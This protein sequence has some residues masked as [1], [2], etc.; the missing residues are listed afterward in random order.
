LFNVSRSI[1][2]IIK[3]TTPILFN[4]SISS[5]KESLQVIDEGF[6]DATWFDRNARISREYSD[7]ISESINTL[8]KDLKEDVRRSLARNA[9]RDRQE[10]LE[11]LLN[12]TSNKF[13]NYYTKERANMIARTNT[14]A[15]DNNVKRDTWTKMGVTELEWVTEGDDRV[16]DSH[17]AMDGQLIPI[18]GTFTIEIYDSQG[19]PTGEKVESPFPAGG[20][21]ASQDV[22]CRCTLLPVTG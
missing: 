13:D 4:L 5:T 10:Q 22:N 18:N 8:D 16:R 6:N 3:K 17:Q 21:T 1:K 9:T 15:V 7:R 19:N 14:T 11:Q 2:N 12:D 20:Q